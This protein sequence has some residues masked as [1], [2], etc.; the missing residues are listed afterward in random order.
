METHSLIPS[1]GHGNAVHLLQRLPRS[2][3]GASEM[4]QWRQVLATKPDDRSSIPGTHMVEGE[5][6]FLQVVLQLP[7]AR[8]STFTH[9]QVNKDVKC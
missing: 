8:A 1:K 3:L 7:H 5:N 6:Q 4:V 2:T 9:T